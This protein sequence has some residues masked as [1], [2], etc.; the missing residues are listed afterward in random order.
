MSDRL[1]ELLR[2]RALLQEHLAWLEREITAASDK[3]VPPAEL[4]LAKIVVPPT[5]TPAA[6]PTLAHSGP[7]IATTGTTRPVPVTAQA[8]EAILEEYRVPPN[9][10]Q[11]DVRR[12]CLLYFAAGFLIFALAVVGLYFAIRSR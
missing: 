5:P 7:V 1:R 9:A 12:G 10:L 6:I 8:A 2:Q 4:P 3:G 11:Q